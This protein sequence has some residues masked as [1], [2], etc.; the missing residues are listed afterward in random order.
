[1]AGDG[2]VTSSGTAFGFGMTKVRRLS[3]GRLA[4]FTGSAYDGSAFCDWLESGGDVPDLEKD[5]FE[6]LVLDTQ[7]VVR[8]YD[9]RGRCIIEEVPIASG[10]GRELALGAMLAGASPM[11]AVSIA[12]ARDCCTGGQ[13]VCLKLGDDA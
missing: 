8:S 1:M 5:S 4:G 6:G 3:D 7:G 13:I 10:S 11:K 12:A 2:L 9:G